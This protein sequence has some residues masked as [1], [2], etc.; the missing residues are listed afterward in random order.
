MWSI[1]T[2][3]FKVGSAAS[4]LYF[5]NQFEQRF[6]TPNK[7]SV[8]LTKLTSIRS[9]NADFAGHNAHSSFERGGQFL[10]EDPA[11]NFQLEFAEKIVICSFQP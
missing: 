5:R 6:L 11:E 4:H 2:R 7:S 8:N 10:V 3:I 9:R 1:L